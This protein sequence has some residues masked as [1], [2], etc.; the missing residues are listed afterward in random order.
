MSMA[1][2]IDN[3]NPSADPL[4][5]SGCHWTA[6]REQS[7]ITMNLISAVFLTRYQAVQGRGESGPCTSGAKTASTCHDNSHLTLCE[8]TKARFCAGWLR[9]FQFCADVKRKRGVCE[10]WIN[11][12]HIA[13]VPAS[14]GEVQASGIAN[15]KGAAKGWR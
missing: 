1:R 5:G 2:A 6:R 15:G 12:R 10:A 9:V 13:T 8:P 3:P 11:M 4:A 7:T 14:A